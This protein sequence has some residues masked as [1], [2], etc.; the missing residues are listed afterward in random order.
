MSTPVGP[1]RLDD[2]SLKE[3]IQQLLDGQAA[4]WSRGDVE[5]F[6][7]GYWHSPE[8]SFASGREVFRGWQSTLDRYR[9][10]YQQDGREMGQLALTDLE[11]EALGPHHAFVRGRWQVTT[12]RDAMS[13]LFTLVLCRLPEGW[14]IIH[15]HTSA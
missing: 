7:S 5:G 13:G 3:E 4:A 8:L 15:D 9:Q 14:R 11:V 10:R 1:L 2:S 12:S 6:M